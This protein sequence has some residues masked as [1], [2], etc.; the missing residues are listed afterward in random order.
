[1]QLLVTYDNPRYGEHEEY[2]TSLTALAK[3]F[4]GTL[5]TKAVRQVL[6]AS[7]TAVMANGYATTTITLKGGM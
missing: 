5:N 4:N 1:M 6:E 3:S 2:T 7:G